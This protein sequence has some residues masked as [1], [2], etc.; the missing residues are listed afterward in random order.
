MLGL[1]EEPGYQREV[2]VRNGRTDSGWVE[3]FALLA[4]AIRVDT[5]LCIPESMAW[6][7]SRAVVA[8]CGDCA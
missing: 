6:V 8:L 7:Q 1:R 4:A 3:M 5:R 2:V